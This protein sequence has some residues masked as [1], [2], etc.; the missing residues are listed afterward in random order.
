MGSSHPKP[1]VFLPLGCVST[2][3]QSD[4]LAGQEK[5]A[6]R[7]RRGYGAEGEACSAGRVGMAGRVTGLCA[8]KRERNIFVFF[9]LNEVMNIERVLIK[10]ARMEASRCC[11]DTAFFAAFLSVC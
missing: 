6:Q 9:L 4:T 7:R 11:L 1:A 10:P 8:P 2:T 5:Q 3:D